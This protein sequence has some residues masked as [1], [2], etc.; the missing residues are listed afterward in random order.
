MGPNEDR[1]IKMDL[2]LISKHEL[3]KTGD[4]PSSEA[5]R[6]LQQIQEIED[7]IKSIDALK[8]GDDAYREVL[9][10]SSKFD[11]LTLAN[12]DSP[13]LYNALARQK[14]ES[15]ATKRLELVRLLV[16][17]HKTKF[18]SRLLTFVWSSL[19]CVQ[20]I[21]PALYLFGIGEDFPA[22]FFIAGAI[23]ALAAGIFRNI[24]TSLSLDV[25]PARK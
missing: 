3:A 4:A 24:S 14:M 2:A 8:K 11:L 16:N 9:I 1:R 18:R 13:E 6:L 10:P 7:E 25:W 23:V 5:Y 17:L 20:S 15:F 12:Q 19:L 22:Y 21:L